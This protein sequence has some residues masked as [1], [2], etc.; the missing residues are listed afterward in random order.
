MV[1]Q[2]ENQIVTNLLFRSRAR[3]G[4]REYALIRGETTDELLQTAIGEVKSLLDERSQQPTELTQDQLI[5][6]TVAEVTL[7]HMEA[8]LG[9]PRVLRGGKHELADTIKA[10]TCIDAAVFAHEI[11]KQGFGRNPQI[12]KR[13]FG[14]LPDHH[15]LE[16]QSGG[17]IDPFFGSRKNSGYFTNKEEF[18]ERLKRLAR[19]SLGGLGLLPFK[20][21]ILKIVRDQ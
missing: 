13:R 1:E 10:A 3:L 4:I 8:G 15:Y 18:E 2:E 12:K 5:E 20:A 14:I 21:L 19:R 11:L 17:I 16:T 9:I 6:K 7:S